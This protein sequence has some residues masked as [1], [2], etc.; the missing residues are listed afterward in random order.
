MVPSTI[1]EAT[2][3]VASAVITAVSTTI[4]SFL[5]VFAM[6]AAEGKLF[7][8]LAFTKTFA[9]LASIILAIT[10]LPPLAH[11]LF[12]IQPKRSRWRYL[13]NLALLVGG[14]ALATMYN[15]WFGIIIVMISLL[16]IASIWIGDHFPGQTTTFYSW[17]KKSLFISSNHY[18]EYFLWSGYGSCCAC[19]REWLLLSGLSK[20]YY[21]QETKVLST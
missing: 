11:S 9:L 15:F 1:F 12:S 5:P 6:E 8:P 2:T 13:S 17:F 19:S 20:Q 16:E 10:I 18:S 14:I 21:I 4:V 3:E 7:R